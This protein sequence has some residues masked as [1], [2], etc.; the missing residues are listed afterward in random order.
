MTYEIITRGSRPMR[1]RT[2]APVPL[3]LPASRWDEAH[4]IAVRIDPYVARLR[5][6][7]MGQHVA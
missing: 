3:L 6:S 2:P 7:W 4:C 1:H 5:A